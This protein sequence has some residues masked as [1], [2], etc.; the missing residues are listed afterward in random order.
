MQAFKQRRGTVWEK[1]RKSKRERK[2]KKRKERETNSTDTAASAIDVYPLLYQLQDGGNIAFL[3]G[4][5]QILFLP[6]G[7][8]PD[9]LR[10][11]R[12]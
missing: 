9:F 2:R 10:V 5:A 4:G 8:P 1:K 3:P 6:H 12:K 7:N 11:K